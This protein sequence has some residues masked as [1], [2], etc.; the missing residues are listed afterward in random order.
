MGRLVMGRGAAVRERLLTDS[1]HAPR[2]TPVRCGSRLGSVWCGWPSPLTAWE[3]GSVEKLAVTSAKVQRRLVHPI[4][5]VCSRCGRVGYPL[6]R[7]TVAQPG[8]RVFAHVLHHH[9]AVHVL[10][11][12]TAAAVDRHLDLKLRPLVEVHLALSSSG[13]RRVVVSFSVR[14]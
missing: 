14:T 2:G 4:L 8:R 5:S 13:S 3:R 10:V 6:R 1:S 12:A 7:P 11:G 9:G